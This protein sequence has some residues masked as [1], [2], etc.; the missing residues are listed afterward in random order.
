LVIIQKQTYIA[1]RMQFDEIFFALET[2]LSNF[3]P[4]KCVDFGEVLE[5]KCSHVSYGQI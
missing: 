2:E 5:D 3:G 1:L 4:G